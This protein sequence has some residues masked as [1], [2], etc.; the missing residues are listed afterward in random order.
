MSDIQSRKSDHLDLAASGDVAFRRK[1]T[2]FECVELVHEALPELSLE[3]VDAS[4]TVLGKRLRSPLLIAGMTGGTQRAGEINRVLA[5]VAQER[6]LAFGVG[7]QRPMLTRPETAE[8]YQVRQHAPDV[9]LFGNIGVVQAAKMQASQVQ[10]LVDAIGADALCVHLNPAMELVQPEGDRDF[11]DGERTLR[12]LQQELGVPLIAKETGCGISARTATRLRG[13]GIEHVDVSGA[14][15]TSWVAVETQRAQDDQR[16]LGELFWDWGIPTAASV[17]ATAAVNFRT[18]I[19]TGGMQDGLQAAKAVALGADL[20][21]I[22]RPVL[23][24]YERAGRDGVVAYLERVETELR[25]AMLLT[26]SKNLKQLRAAPRRIGG[27]LREWQE[28]WSQ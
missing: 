3:Q 26:G 13:L 17:I 15:G 25:T 20:V 27:A 9:L 4:C 7:S 6:C 21:G 11:R 16:A 22:A 18:V 23:Q 1:T 24:A 8:S 12:R 5:E 19:A 28:L 14:G 10:R 2:L